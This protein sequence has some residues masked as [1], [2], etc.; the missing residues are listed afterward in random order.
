MKINDSLQV[1]D[2][3][4][5]NDDIIEEWTVDRDTAFEI[6]WHLTIV[7]KIQNLFLKELNK[8]RKNEYKFTSIRFSI[9]KETQ[10]L[11]YFPVYIIDY[12]YQNRQ[13]QCLINGRT[14][15]VA[16][17]RQFSQL[18]VRLISN[19]KENIVLST[20]GNGSNYWNYLSC[21]YYVICFY[22]FI[23]FL[24][25]YS[26]FCC[27]TISFTFNWNNISYCDDRCFTNRKIYSR[28][29]TFLS[30]KT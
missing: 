2:V 14:G 7:N 3:S 25:D 19:K 20:L 27:H 30:R 17:L 29:F 26:T 13:L 11:I 4:S 8:Q 10:E 5:L 9:D 6:S 24:C 22:F 1:I 28:L 15:Q 16:G 12:Q 23:C 18:K 21:L